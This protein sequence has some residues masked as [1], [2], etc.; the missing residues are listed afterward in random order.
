MS[1]SP[2]D[3][4]TLEFLDDD[5]SS[6]PDGAR[7]VLAGTGG[8]YRLSPEWPRRGLRRP[9]HACHRR[10]RPRL[11]HGCPRLLSSCASHGCC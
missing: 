5:D 8:S 3:H 1:S 2:Q 11:G 9:W 7:A 4:T 6:S 10:P